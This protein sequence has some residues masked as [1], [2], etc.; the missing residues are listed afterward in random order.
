MTCA[1]CAVRVERALSSHPGID[2]ASVNFASG[3]ARVRAHPGIDVAGVRAAV[4]QIGYDLK[5]AD[6]ADHSHAS[7]MHD[8]N[9]GL[10]WRR[11]LVAAVLS[12]PLLLLAMAGHTADWSRWRVT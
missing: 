4:Q 8:D 5:V 11:F 12:A 6:A 10:Q 1:S 3:K 7:H 9:E 2:Q